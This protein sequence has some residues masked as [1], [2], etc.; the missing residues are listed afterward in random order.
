MPVSRQASRNTHCKP[1]TGRYS[2]DINIGLVS[3]SQASLR[4][5]IRQ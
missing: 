4:P 2:T 1:S 3:S 5:P